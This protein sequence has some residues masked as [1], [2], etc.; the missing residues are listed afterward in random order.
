MIYKRG[1][2]GIYWYEFVWKE[3]RIR[4]STRQTNPR[5]ARQIEAAHR[6][7]LAKG[8]VGIRDR[9]TAPTLK[10]F[11]EQDFKAYVES[12]F[13]EKPKTKDYYLH[14][15]KFLCAYEPLARERLNA[16]TAENITGFVGSRQTKG[17]KVAAINR[18]LE[19][20][21]RMLK[22]A[23]EWGKVDKLLPN[24]RML[25]GEQRRDRVVTT[26]EEKKFL[27]ASKPLLRDVATVL[28]DCAVRPEECFRM[29]RD[30]VRDGAIHVQHG[31]T[32]AARRRVPMSDRVQAIIERRLSEHASEWVFPAPT[33]SGHIEPS[34]CKRQQMLAFQ[35]CQV[36]PFPLY[37]LRHTCLTRWAPHMDPY[38]LAYLAGHS[39]MRITKRYVHPQ[40]ETVRQAMERA[41]GPHKSPHN[42]ETANSDLAADSTANTSK[43]VVN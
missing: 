18:E 4:E 26:E 30:D 35:Q 32:E 9:K 11:A 1:K 31:K 40:D 33:Q 2:G 16:I 39:N 22:L 28:V 24:V 41:S 12:T 43:Q 6:T 8:E 38:T 27:L 10:D 17:R 42:A 25:P 29:R 15:V 34:S 7:S 36:K 19:V 37:S 14:G 20:L 13:T 21:R 5:V 23:V 3:D